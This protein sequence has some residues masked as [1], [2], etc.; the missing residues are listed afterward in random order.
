[1]LRT[2]LLVLILLVPCTAQPLVSEGRPG[3]P[4][5]NHPLFLDKK[6]LENGEITQ[7]RL[8]YGDTRDNSPDCLNTIDVFLG[9]ELFEPAAEKSWVLVD[10]ELQSILIDSG[11]FGDADV[12]NVRA[13]GEMD[14]CVELR[15]KLEND[16]DE[17]AKRQIREKPQNLK[18]ARL[19]EIDQELD[20]GRKLVKAARCRGCHQMEGFGAEHA[21]GLTWKRYKYVAGWLEKYL[22]TPYR[23]RP[24][25]GD[26]MM[27]QYT[28]A[29][30][31]PS[32]QEIEVK[33]IA[34]FLER[35]AKAKTPN[36]RYRKEAWQDYDCFACHTSNYKNR[37]LPFTPTPVPESLKDQL[38]GNQ[39][40]QLCLSCHAFGDYRQVVPG[41]R[42]NPNR[43]AP[44]LLLTMEKLDINYLLNYPQNPDYLQPGSQMPAVPLTRDQQDQ[45]RQFVLE[46]RQQIDSGAVTPVYNYYRMEKVSE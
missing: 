33:A 30:A 8:A 26:L 32:L 28:S 15:E 27:L 23:L 22:R 21:P 29:N 24:A 31:R 11:F 39:T 1:M 19:V 4:Y 40:L 46:L 44:D 10:Y 42:D 37:P 41:E 9:L 16:P 2:T 12:F 36:G 3:V 38:E 14:A 18:K 6:L 35:V 34:S 20:V 43:F 7:V 25:M 13:C 5:Y 17:L 45:L